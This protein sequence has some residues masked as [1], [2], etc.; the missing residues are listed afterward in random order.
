MFCRNNIQ[1]QKK[2]GVITRVLFLLLNASMEHQEKNSLLFTGYFYFFFTNNFVPLTSHLNSQSPT[3]F[4]SNSTYILNLLKLAYPENPSKL[5]I[6]E[7]CKQE[8]FSHF[9]WSGKTRQNL[10]V[11]RVQQQVTGFL[12]KLS[13]FFIV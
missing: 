13:K 4:S 12:P 6:V 11:Q 3:D 10:Q 9:S 1:A 5:S 7:F 2:L 8:R